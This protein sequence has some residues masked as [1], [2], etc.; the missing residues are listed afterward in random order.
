M[1]KSANFYFLVALIAIMSWV[2]ITS[3]SFKRLEAQLLP[4]LTSVITI[5]LAVGG[6]L[7]ERLDRRK[8]LVDER[9]NNTWTPEQSRRLA[10]IMGW[11]LVFFFAIFL[12]GFL[13]AI[14]LSTLLYLKM[15]G[16]P[17]RTAVTFAAMLTIGVYLVFELGLKSDLYQ[18]LLFSVIDK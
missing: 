8:Q 13:A 5:L 12:L 14:P 15:R 16:R 9:E 11:V 1:K 3:L 4:L 7:V 10:A 17:W 2:A 18:G 6:M